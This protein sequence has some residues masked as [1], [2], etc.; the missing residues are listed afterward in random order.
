[1]AGIGMFHMVA[2]RITSY[3]EGSAPVYG[4]GFVIGP[5]VEAKVT[6]NRAD[7]PDM[8]D[9]VVI[10][11]D[12]GITGYDA[13]LENNYLT[14]EVAAKL[15]GWAG[16]GTT[17]SPYVVTSDPSPD[18]G[19]GYVKKCMNR[20]TKCYRAF[21]FLRAKASMGSY[22]NGKTKVRN[23][24][25]WQHDTSTLRGESVIEDSSGKEH[26]FYP[27]TFDTMSGA[28]AWLDA[29]ANISSSSS[30]SVNQ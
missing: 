24:V 13:S 3:T 1:M 28:E 30:G 16:A 11:D 5:A 19:W 4:T 17:E 29:K 15:Y 9:D 25:E 8:G 10:D 27:K 20:G 18:I 22:A 21:W 2:A 6:F 23:G 12:N 14:E 26:W 7:N